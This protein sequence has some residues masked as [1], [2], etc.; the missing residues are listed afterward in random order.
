MTRYLVDTSAYSAYLRGHEGL[1]EAMQTAQTL[2]INCVV[3]GEL[4]AGFKKGTRYEDNMSW[5]QKFLS[6]PR[7]TVLGVDQDTADRYSEIFVHLQRR[8]SPIPTNDVW[9]A[10]SAMQH[11]FY[12][13]TTDPHFERVDQV[14]VEYHAA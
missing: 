5:L 3:L 14:F 4:L 10:A 8:G 7:V 9:I 13:L 2:A 6:S 11:G 12:V 1:R